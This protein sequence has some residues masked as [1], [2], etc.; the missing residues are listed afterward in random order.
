MSMVRSPRAGIIGLLL[1]MTLMLSGCPAP[2]PAEPPAVPVEPT[3]APAGATSGTTPADTTPVPVSP[4]AAVATP[5][6][7][8]L[9]D[10]SGQIAFVSKFIQADQQDDEIQSINVDGTGAAAFEQ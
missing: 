6:L 1:L 2:E 10:R 7:E 4:T 9:D 3:T 5:V 8:P